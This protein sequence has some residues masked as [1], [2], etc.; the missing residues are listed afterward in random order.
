M[1]KAIKVKGTRDK[2]MN[3][4]LD[5]DYMHY[6][7]DRYKD[8]KEEII[9][10]YI[11]SP[12]L[13]VAIARCRRMIQHKTNNKIP[14]ELLYKSYTK[15]DY[16]TL[17]SLLQEVF[18]EYITTEQFQFVLDKLNGDSSNLYK[19]YQKHLENRDRRLLNVILTL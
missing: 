7:I 8:Y 17:H 12:S 4:C 19:L 10:I 18:I 16:N 5:Y 9:D 3:N 13:P 14:Y 6:L 2:N 15:H 11:N 1:T